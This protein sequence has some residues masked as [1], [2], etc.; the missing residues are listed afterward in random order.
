M[1]IF[2]R[3]FRN[4]KLK[5]LFSRYFLIST[6]S[7]ARPNAFNFFFFQR[8]LNLCPKFIDFCFFNSLTQQIFIKISENYFFSFFFFLKNFFELEFN[9]LG[10]I[11][12]VDFPSRSARFTLF[13]NLISIKLN[14]RLFLFLDF[15]EMTVI[16]SLSS[17]FFSA[18]CLEREVW[19]LFGI[20]FTQHPDLRRILS[21]YGFDGFALRKDFPLT[22]YVEVR[23]EEISKRIIYEP[24]ELSQAYRFFD[25]QTPWR[26]FS[27]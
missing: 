24:I 25:F 27:I 6:L 21:D 5:L 9:I 18:N 8:L 23:F 3:F 10:D 11:C 19:D 4:N 15:S 17:I 22:G 16:P 2:F 13:Y 20:F 14:L 12:A 7:F 1:V 26:P